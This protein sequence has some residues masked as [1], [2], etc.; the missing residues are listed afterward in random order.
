MSDYADRIREIIQEAES[1]LLEFAV[2]ISD[3]GSD[4]FIIRDGMDEEVIW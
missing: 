2:D 3:S 4:R 1:E